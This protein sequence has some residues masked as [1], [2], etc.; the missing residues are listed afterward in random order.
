LPLR[1]AT[2]SPSPSPD[3][4][5]LNVLLA[6]FAKPGRALLF[7]GRRGT[8]GRPSIDTERIRR[9]ADFFPNSPLDRQA[10]DAVLAPVIGFTPT[11]F[12]LLPGLFLRRQT[13]H[14]DTVDAFALDALAASCCPSPAR[15]G[16][17]GG[18]TAWPARM[19]TAIFAA[20][21]FLPGIRCRFRVEPGG[22]F[23]ARR[24]LAG[25]RFLLGGPVTLARPLFL[26]LEL[27]L[28]VA[29]DP[30]P[31]GGMA[32]IGR[33]ILPGLPPELIEQLLAGRLRRR[34][35][36]HCDYQGKPDDESFDYANVHFTTRLTHY[37][38][39][40]RRS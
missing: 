12:L 34:Q 9:G 23:L 25:R 6:S 36:W 32:R 4:G 14:L 33:M 21:A 20:L 31:V 40:T 19:G 10:V 2:Q 24:T 7:P 35:G 28:P 13:A 15:P 30:R 5:Q 1:T 38:Q 17:V 39:V 27:L 3:P 37:F 11:V 22:L 16:S 29:I 26:L 18:D 8:A